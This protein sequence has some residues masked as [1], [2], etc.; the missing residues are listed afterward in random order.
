MR[1][2]RKTATIPP[3]AVVFDLDGTIIDQRQVYQQLAKAR[4][5]TVKGADLNYNRIKESVPPDVLNEIDVAYMGDGTKAAP[6]MPGALAV[7]RDFSSQAYIV[8]ARGTEYERQ[9]RSWLQRNLPVFPDDHFFVFPSTPAKGRFLAELE[10]AIVVDDQI[11][12]L[13]IIPAQS[14][15]LLLDPDGAFPD[16][17]VAGLRVVRSWDEIR[18]VLES[19]LK[20]RV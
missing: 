20:R 12:P 7:L 13:K 16:A 3:G 19:T 17:G 10:P 1:I 5:Y 6:P 14:V 11:A 2:R 8:S 4:G 18:Q 9:G 15:R